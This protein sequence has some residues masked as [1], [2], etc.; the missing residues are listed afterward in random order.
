MVGGSAVGGVAFTCDEAGNVTEGNS[1]EKVNCVE[2]LMC[3]ENTC[4]EMCDPTNDMCAT[5]AR[6]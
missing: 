5:S 6:I 4:C 3:I 1:Y 2:G